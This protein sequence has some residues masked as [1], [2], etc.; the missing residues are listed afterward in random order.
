M[1]TWPHHIDRFK[2]QYDNVFAEYP[3]F[4][5]DL[6]DWIHKHVQVSLHSS[7]TTA[8]EEVESG[9]LEKFWGLQKRVE[10]GKWMTSM[11]VWGERLAPWEEGRRKS[12]GNG[13]GAHNHGVDPQLRISK[14]LGILKK[15]A[16]LENL[17]LPM[18][19]DGREICLCYISKGE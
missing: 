13:T 1:G 8:I 6:M 11:H 3:L 9:A 18:G 15:F 12:E 14:N 2:R 17:R 4:G 5:A 7:N 10:R 19:A 16:L